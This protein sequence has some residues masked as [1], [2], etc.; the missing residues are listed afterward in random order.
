MNDF[1]TSFKIEDYTGWKG[2]QC[3]PFNNHRGMVERTSI[4][5][6]MGSKLDSFLRKKMFLVLFFHV[7]DN[8]KKIHQS[9]C[10]TGV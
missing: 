3:R 8:E 2:N 9:V 10:L 1:I 7:R 4:I 5:Y 6:N